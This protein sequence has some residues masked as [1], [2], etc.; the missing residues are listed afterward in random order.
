[1]RTEFPNCS[2]RVQESIATQSHVF[3]WRPL[4]HLHRSSARRTAASLYQPHRRSLVG[5]R[6]EK[7]R[8]GLSDEGKTLGEDGGVSIPD[9]D[10]VA[11]RG[12]RVETNRARDHKGRGFR[13]EIREALQG[14]GR[15]ARREQG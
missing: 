8:S 14:R 2:L 3:H 15:I 7:E 9:L 5:E 11:A 6:V 1:M 12:A 10:V 4:V 13:F